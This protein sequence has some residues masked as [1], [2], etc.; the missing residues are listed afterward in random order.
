MAV[1]A[2]ALGVLALSLS[3][4]GASWAL[5]ADPTA[6]LPAK[7]D[8]V[9]PVAPP[10]PLSI[11]VVTVNGKTARTGVWIDAQVAEAQK[12]YGRFG[13][14]FRKAE[15]RRLAPRFAEL[16]TTKDRDA[17]ASELKPGVI[18]VFV[19]ASLHDSEDPTMYRMGV[20]WAPNGN[21]KK[22]YVIVSADAGKTT[23]AHEVGHYFGL[24]HTDVTDN[25]MSYKREGPDIVLN[26]FQAKKVVASVK[27]YLAKKELVPVVE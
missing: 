11:A 21:L 7:A 10:L 6:A 20:H 13:V 8:A 9:A 18:N 19:V 14:S 15:V 25:L 1:G 4:G 27:G 2:M 12:I 23:M 3:L 24:Q 17:L 5:A 26:P 22:Q 16:V